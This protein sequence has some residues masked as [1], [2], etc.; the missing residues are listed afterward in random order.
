MRLKK[1][2]RKNI[3][4]TLEQ[5][6][7]VVSDLA[8][9]IRYRKMADRIS[10]GAVTFSEIFA[11]LRKMMAC[12]GLTKLETRR[13]R[14]YYA[15]YKV[16][17]LTHRQVKAATGNFHP[18]YI[19]SEMYFAYIDP[20]LNSREKATGLESK[21]MFGRLFPGIP[22][23]G[24]LAYR[25]NGYWSTSDYRPITFE[26]VI[27]LANAEEAVFVKQSDDSFGGHGVVRVTRTANAALGE[28]LA[29][30]AEELKGDLVLQLPI[31]QHADLARFNPSSVNTYRIATLLTPEG[32]VYVCRAML[33]TGVGDVPV[34]N[35]TSGGVAIGIDH[36]GCLRKYGYSGNGTITEA[37]PLTGI[38]Y[39][40]YV[41]PSFKRAVALAKK[42]HPMLP[43]FRLISW[44]FAVEENGQPVLVEANL[45]AG[46]IEALQDCNG[47]FFRKMTRKVVQ[48]ALKDTDFPR[49]RRQK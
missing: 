19:P 14:A 33:R 5:K 32:Q 31:H 24:V 40:G 2:G 8:Y 4:E 17:T 44:D 49:I 30:A 27:A 29:R 28:A 42:A 1:D 12:P 13:V 43:S 36:R 39:E 47:P 3:R 11:K 6:I 45:T 46:G 38:R 7:S 23:P 48:E 9:L 41:L 22:Q 35:F 15:P 10:Y 26:E 16:S 18:A 20:Y 25:V 37:H 34:D 21:C